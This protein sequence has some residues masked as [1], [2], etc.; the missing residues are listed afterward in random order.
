VIA[1]SISECRRILGSAADGKTDEQI[2]CLCDG[3]VVVANEAYDSLT[4]A[5]AID[6]ETLQAASED[7][8]GFP[9]TS[10]EQLR[11]AAVDRVRWIAHAHEHGI[12]DGE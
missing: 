6:S 8:P 11:R 1:I 3:L 2:E 12:E 5:I 4:R 9:A 10:E 7:V